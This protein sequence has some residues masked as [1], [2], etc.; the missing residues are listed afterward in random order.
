MAEHRHNDAPASAAAGPEAAATE[1]PGGVYLCQVS[2]TVSCGACCGLYNVADP[3]RP[4]LEAML[5]RRTARFG[6]VPRELDAILAFQ[7]AI[8]AEE[9]QRRPYPDFH[10]CPFIGLIGPAPGRVGCLLHPLADGNAGVDWRGLSDYGG[11]ACR[12]YFC[13]ATQRLPARYKTVLR[14]VF[15]HWH[16]FGLIATERHLVT[17]LLSALEERLGRLLDPGTV[18]ADP[19]RTAALAALLGIKLDWPYRR[20]DSH[21]CHFLFED[22]TVVRPAVGDADDKTAFEPYDI[23][24]R[25]LETAFGSIVQRRAAR[26]EVDRRL[27]AAVGALRG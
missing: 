2:A 10:H 9:C 26:Q 8:A 3:T 23:I 25:E 14:T 24:F 27:E 1:V 11:M 13:P 15:D 21:L 20:P 5:S 6:P 17:A 19:G 18:A 16:P 7:N 22:G 4:A 12:V